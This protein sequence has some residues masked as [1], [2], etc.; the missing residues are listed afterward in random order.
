VY[1]WVA[2]VDMYTRAEKRIMSHL[3][4]NLRDTAPNCEDVLL[5]L[6]LLLI[7]A[8]P[9]PPVPSSETF[10]GVALVAISILGWNRSVY[11]GTRDAFWASPHERGR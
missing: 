3:A 8:S 11:R 10:I 2:R 5:L 9:T 1:Q 4:A 7:S 6:C